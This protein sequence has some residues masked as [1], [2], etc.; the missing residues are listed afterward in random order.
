MGVEVA[1]QVE[2]AVDVHVLGVAESQTG[3]IPSATEGERSLVYAGDCIDCATRQDGHRDLSFAAWVDSVGRIAWLDVD[4]DLDEREAGAGAGEADHL[5]AAGRVVGDRESSRP[6]PTARPSEAYPNAPVRP[7]R[8]ITAARV[9]LSEVPARNNAGNF[10]W[11]AARVVQHGSLR[12]AGR[13]DKLFSER[14]HSREQGNERAVQKH[15]NRASLVSSNDICR[16]IAVDIRCLKGTRKC[17]ACIGACLF[18]KRAITVAE[19]NRPGDDEVQFP[20]AIEV[21]H[22]QGKSARIKEIGWESKRD[23][24]GP[25]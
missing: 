18:A 8:Y 13:P 12:C 2:Q 11:C 1:D 15:G 10:Q 20:V 22:R 19:Q 7:P 14:N 16:T 9:G 25:Q 17:R 4:G 6:R 24:T 5:R 23:G 3:F 21:S